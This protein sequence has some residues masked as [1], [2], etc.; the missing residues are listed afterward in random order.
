M[1]RANYQSPGMKKKD[2]LFWANTVIATI[3]ILVCLQIELLNNAAGG[4]LPHIPDSKWRDST[5]VS[6]EMW[7]KQQ[8]YSKEDVTLLTRPLT[9]SER[10]QMQKDIEQADTMNALKG[11]VSGYGIWQYIFA[12][13][14]LILSIVMAISRRP[15]YKR[16]MCAVFAL[17]SL[18]AMVLMFYRGYFTSLG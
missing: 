2:A 1:A 5:P 8:R 15:M 7:R 3:V 14:A 16:I 11:M 18:I 4:Y 10:L 6:E 12:P 17:S 9:E 13:V